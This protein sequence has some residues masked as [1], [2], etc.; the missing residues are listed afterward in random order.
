V[1]GGAAG[2]GDAGGVTADTTGAAAAGPER[3]TNSP[4]NDD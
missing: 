3:N 1:A 2:T 4:K